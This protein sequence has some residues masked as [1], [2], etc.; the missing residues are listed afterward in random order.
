[1]N[2]EF[3]IFAFFYRDINFI[4]VGYAE[5]SE[6]SNVHI[7]TANQDTDFNELIDNLPKWSSLSPSSTQPPESSLLSQV[8]EDLYAPALKYAANSR[9]VQSFKKIIGKMYFIII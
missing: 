8:P 6:D 9:I 7:Y 4:I 3:T 2:S 1:L 5:N